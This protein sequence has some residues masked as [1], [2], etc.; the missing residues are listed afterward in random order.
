MLRATS[1]IAAIVIGL[2]MLVNPVVAADVSKKSPAPPVKIITES[3]PVLHPNPSMKVRVRVTISE[4]IDIRTSNESNIYRQLHFAVLVKVPVWDVE[5]ICSAAN[6]YFEARSQSYEG[7]TAI[8]YVALSRA[9]SDKFPDTLCKV[10]TQP[11]QFSWYK[12]GSVYIIDDLQS[13]KSAVAV[14]KGA[15]KGNLIDP[16]YGALYYHTASSSPYWSEIFTYIKSIDDHKF[17]F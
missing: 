9:K 12:P 5:L 2:F 16:S 6:V 10:V 15:R 17:Y 4:E 8:A 13:W 1:N 7:Q 3:I 14:V 11:N